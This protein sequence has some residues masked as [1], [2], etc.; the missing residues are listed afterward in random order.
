MSSPEQK[1]FINVDPG[2]DDGFDLHQEQIIDLKQMGRNGI[3][4]IDFT[5]PPE[6]IVLLGK[7][8]EADSLWRNMSERPL[9]K[10]P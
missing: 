3:T 1:G 6:G 7:P 10:R 4:L 8:F 5:H 9:P 2:G